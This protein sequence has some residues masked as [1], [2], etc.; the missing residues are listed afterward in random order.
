MDK[1]IVEAAGGGAVSGFR[2][3]D[4][5]VIDVVGVPAKGAFEIALDL[6]QVE[7][8]DEV[9]ILVNGQEDRREVTLSADRKSIK[10]FPPGL[11]IFVK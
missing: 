8:P 2:L 7:L 6:S 10:G 4:D 5:G 1:I 3:A 9:T 11:V